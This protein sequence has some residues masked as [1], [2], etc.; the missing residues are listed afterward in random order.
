MIRELFLRP[1]HF[2]IKYLRMKIKMN[3]VVSLSYDL[4][5]G[6][7]GAEKSFVESANAE[8]PLTFIFGLGGLIPTFEANVDGLVKGDKFAFDIPAADAYGIREDNA[9]VELPIDV[10]MMDGKIEEGLLEVGSMIP[11]S[12]NDNNRLIGKVIEVTDANVKMDFN[13]ELAGKDLRFEGEVLDVREATAE[14]IDHGHVHDGDGHHHA[15]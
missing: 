6:D 11:M 7:Q 12:D 8:N 14:E 10:F 1:L 4:Y 13:H 15:H 9:L 3:A 5:A 2:T